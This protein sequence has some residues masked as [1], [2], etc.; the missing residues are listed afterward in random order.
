MARRPRMKSFDE[1]LAEAMEDFEANGYDSAERLAHWEERLRQAA[2]ASM[3]PDHVMEEKLKEHLSAIYR[4]LIERGGILSKHPGV[5]RYTLAKLRP[6]LHRELSRRIMASANLIR[7]HKDEEIAATLR[8]FS[9]WATAVP[10]DGSDNVDKR[11]EKESIRKSLSGLSFRE[12]RVFIDQGHK[13]ESAISMTVAQGGGAIAGI[14][15]SHWRQANY[16]Y[17]EDHKERDGELY[18]VRGNWA[19]ERGLMRLGGRKYID[20]ITEPGEEVYCRCWYQW[21]YAIR[22]LPDDMIT[23]KGRQAMAEARAAA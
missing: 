10:K 11:R 4:R 7:L 23:K 12:R 19:M 16:D 3:T 14:W 17:R 22:R 5:A 9:G 18:V 2:R 13:L 20:E 8:R 21:V 15:H 1:V 6:E